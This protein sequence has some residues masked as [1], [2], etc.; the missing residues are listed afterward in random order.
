MQSILDH[1]TT[2]PPVIGQYYIDK[3]TGRLFMVTSVDVMVSLESVGG[4]LIYIPQYL[5]F[6]YYE[7]VYNLI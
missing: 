3:E 1:I 2:K 7:R 5:L 6:E 4:S